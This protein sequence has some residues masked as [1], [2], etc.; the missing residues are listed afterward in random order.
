MITLIISFVMLSIVINN[1][2]AELITFLN[3]RQEK[4]CMMFI[5]IVLLVISIDAVILKHVRE[6]MWLMLSIWCKKS[7]NKDSYYNVNQGASD[8]N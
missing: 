4:Q 1:G 2:D 6:Q 3:P 7:D 8:Q 5:A